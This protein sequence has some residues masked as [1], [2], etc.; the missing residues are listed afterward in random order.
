MSLPD[1]DVHSLVVH[2]VL[3]FMRSGFRV[4][5][6]A[7]LRQIVKSRVEQLLTVKHVPEVGCNLPTSGFTDSK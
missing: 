1:S 6:T 3:S 7:V 4:T 5:N 2:S